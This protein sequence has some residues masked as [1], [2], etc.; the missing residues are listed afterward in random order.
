VSRGK[1]NRRLPDLT[2]TPEMWEAI[3]RDREQGR[4][5]AELVVDTGGGRGPA[6]V[7]G[8]ESLPPGNDQGHRRARP[9]SLTDE[10]IQRYRREWVKTITRPHRL[11]W[12]PPELDLADCPC[13]CTRDRAC[14]LHAHELGGPRPY[15]R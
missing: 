12:V 7:A 2:I 15:A 4:R 6:P 8:R 13:S 1:K 14:A 10:Q 11:P 5:G 3:S 9:R